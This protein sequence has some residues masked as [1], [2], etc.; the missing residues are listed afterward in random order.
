MNYDIKLDKLKMYMK[1]NKWRFEHFS[2]YLEKA[3]Y[4]QKTEIFI[5]TPKDE[6][7]SDYS[8]RVKQI[9]EKLSIIH[10]ISKEAVF[11]QIKYINYDTLKIKL[12]SKIENSDLLPLNDYSEIVDNL[13]KTIKFSICSEWKFK[14][15]YTKPYSY[16]DLIVEKSFVG[17]SETG[18]YVFNFHIPILQKPLKPDL[19]LEDREK[20]KFLGRNSII[21][22]INGLEDSKNI[23]I[24]S[25]SAFEGYYKRLS[26][27]LSKNVFDH[28]SNLMQS[29][30][31]YNLE[32]STSFDKTIKDFLLEEEKIIKL[33][34]SELYKKFVKCSK[35]LDEKSEGKI[36][37]V[38]G[39]IIEMKKDLED[40]TLD[41]VIKDKK[42]KK[43]LFISMK[44][45]T[46]FYNLFFEAFK[47][48]RKI[49]SKGTIWKNEEINRWCFENTEK[50]AI[51]TGLTDFVQSSISRKKNSNNS[52]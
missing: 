1:R 12:K 18:S 4:S 27:K 17:Q 36:S 10:N 15:R 43:N 39:Y 26:N 32:F 45:T 9:I 29:E 20:Q 21:H 49:Y 31:G 13:R 38:E 6:T 25:K 33:K 5:M 11:N 28:I 34:A 30:T 44:T 35:Y 23:D 47:Y 16:A 2:E 19:D 22:L 48:N 14:R 46:E 41:F 3:I 52:N 42:I 24:S 40:N 8:Q 50:Y 51:Q 37:N 7:V